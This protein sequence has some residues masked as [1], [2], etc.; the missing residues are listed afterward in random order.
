GVDDGLEPVAADE[1]RTL[2][3]L[4]SRRE[5]RLGAREHDAAHRC[6]RADPHGHEP[7]ERE[8]DDRRVRV[9]ELQHG[10]ADVR[11]GERLLRHRRLAVP[12][13]VD[14]HDPAV[15]ERL[16]LRLPHRDR[17]AERADEDDRIAVA[18]DDVMEP[19]APSTLLYTSTARSTNAPAAP[20]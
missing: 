15:A 14:A 6:V 10:A 20:R 13:E 3:P 7:A 1:C 12:G 11:N 19:H 18:L 5:R 9:D 2:L 8:A 16:E 17:R 4:R